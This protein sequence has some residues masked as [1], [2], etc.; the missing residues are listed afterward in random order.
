MH[1]AQLTSQ[2]TRSQ[3]LRSF[4]APLL[5]P[6]FEALCVYEVFEMKHIRKLLV[7]QIFL[8][9]S[10][11]AHSEW[12]QEMISVSCV[13][14][15]GFFNV[16]PHLISSPDHLWD[17]GD[18]STA[19]D[20]VIREDKRLLLFNEGILL[21]GSKEFKC[22]EYSV[23][24]DRGITLKYKGNIIL[25]NQRFNSQA[26]F[27]GR[28]HSIKLI[29]INVNY[30]FLTIEFKDHSGGISR[31]KEVWGNANNFGLITPNEVA[32]YKRNTHVKKQ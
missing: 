23:S 27:E 15:V 18:K 13:D 8:L 26:S 5:T 31:Y 25:K 4:V 19:S 3:K 22:R 9:V 32:S 12:M 10:F 16:K 28:P 11:S 17:Y 1:S 30:S 21:P 24:L 14:D 2:S 6:V 7:T 29:S 20:N